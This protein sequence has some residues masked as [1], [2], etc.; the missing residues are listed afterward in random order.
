MQGLA[1]QDGE[2]IVY[3]HRGLIPRTLDYLF[4]QINQRSSANVQFLCKC[5][6]VE[7]YNENIFDLLDVAAP[8]CSI[9]EDL[10]KGVWIEGIAEEV[11]ATP[12]EAYDVLLRGAKNRHVAETCMN[13]ES[14]RSHAV[15]TLYIQCKI[16]ISP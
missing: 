1:S 16:V 4:A 14:S 2:Q 5:S 3:S 15:F 9:R 7:I 6:F 12:Q 10:K 11:I 8:V 13:R